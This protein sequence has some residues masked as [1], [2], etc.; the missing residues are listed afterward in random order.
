MK[1]G[2]RPE[3]KA[4]SALSRGWKGYAQL[5]ASSAACHA[6]SPS[7][8]L[9]LPPLIVSLSTLLPFLI[10]SR[11]PHSPC[12]QSPEGAAARAS[13]EI[14]RRSKDGDVCRYLDKK[15]L[16]VCGGCWWSWDCA[17][18][19][20]QSS[21]GVLRAVPQALACVQQLY[22][23]LS[24]EFDLSLSSAWQLAVA[25]SCWAGLCLVGSLSVL[26]SACEGHPRQS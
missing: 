22:V 16:Y 21:T 24:L 13:E 9:P 2:A 18:C 1:K 8:C 11:R 23:L 15:R 4:P 19:A 5:P 10:H 17:W 3:A 7:P 20:A 26:D 25:A 6:F 12:E 14:R